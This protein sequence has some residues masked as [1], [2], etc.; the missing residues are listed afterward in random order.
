LPDLLHLRELSRLDKVVLSVLFA[1]VVLALLGLR[2]PLQMLPL[3]FVEFLWKA[4]W[5]V[6]SGSPLLLANGEL[7]PAARQT[8]TVFVMVTVLIPIVVPWGYVLRH[9]V[10]ARRD[11]VSQAGA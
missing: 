9:Y 6:T 1:Q 3:L 10:G 2:Y 5:L 8:L 7:T 11:P 4:L